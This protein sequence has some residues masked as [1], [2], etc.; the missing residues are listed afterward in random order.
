MGGFIVLEDGRAC[1]PS[2]RGTNVMLENI[3]AQIRDR[4]FRDWI[5][6]QR[7]TST[8]MGMTNIDLRELTPGNRDEFHRATR[9]AFAAIS[10]ADPLGDQ[11]YHSYLEC[12]SDLVEMMDRVDRGEPP[13][14][15]NPHMRGLISETQ[16]RRAPGWD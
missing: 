14:Q 2:S 5:L 6:S 9:E 11:W 10:A 8:G 1:A 4:E 7:S 3:A 13:E 16:A 12:F 15:F